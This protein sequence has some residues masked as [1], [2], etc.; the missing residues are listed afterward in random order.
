[1]IPM[2]P[3]APLILKFL[4]GPASSALAD[5]NRENLVPIRSTNYSAESKIAVTGNYAEHG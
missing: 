4:A 2:E 1:M 3:A 5:G